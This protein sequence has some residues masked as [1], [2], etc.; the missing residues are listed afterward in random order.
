[1]NFRDQWWHPATTPPGYRLDNHDS[2][3]VDSGQIASHTSKAYVRIRLNLQ[4]D[5]A[6]ILGVNQEEIGSLSWSHKPWTEG[7]SD[8]HE[9]VVLSRR[10]VNFFADESRP[11]LNVM[12][13]QRNESGIAERVAVGIVD[14]EEWLRLRPRWEYIVIG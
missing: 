12:L 13:I 7:N 10:N 8:H 4:D 6:I 9:L 3:F 1:V 2:Q 14:E 5:K 11:A